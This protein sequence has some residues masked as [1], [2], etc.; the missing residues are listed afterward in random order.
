M[1][2]LIFS[3]ILKYSSMYNIDPLL[4]VSVIETESSFNYKAISPGFDSGLFQLNP[5][6]FPNYTKKQLLNPET[7]I[8]LGIEFLSKMKKNCVHKKNNEWVICFNVGLAGAKKIKYPHLFP[9]VVK[10]ERNYRSLK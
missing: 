4:V 10:I 9:Y 5:K 3:L 2:A 1:Y 7:N 6:S 8:R